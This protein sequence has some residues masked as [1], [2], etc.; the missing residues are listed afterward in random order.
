LK[1]LYDLVFLQV[2]PMNMYFHRKRHVFVVQK[3][4]NQLYD[5]MHSFRL[6]KKKMYFRHLITLVYGSQNGIYIVS[7]LIWNIFINLRR[8]YFI[9]WHTRIHY[10]Y[11][12]VRFLKIQSCLLQSFFN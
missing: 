8:H 2:H 12:D 6:L 10:N 5:F 3:I 7:R 1:F 9:Y 11:N 4:W